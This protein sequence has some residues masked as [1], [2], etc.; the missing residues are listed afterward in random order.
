MRHLPRAVLAALAVA[1]L[2][3]AGSGCGGEADGGPVRASDRAWTTF[4]DTR[5]GLSVSLPPGWHRAR[6]SLTPDLADPREVLSVGSYRPRYDRRSRCAVPGCPS[7]GLHGLRT[8]DVLISIQE[9]GGLSRRFGRSPG[10]TFPARERPFELEPRPVGGKGALGRCARRKLAWWAWTPFGEAG[11]GFYAFV[12]VGRDA[13]PRT[14][15]ELRRVLDS[16]RFRPPRRAAGGWRRLNPQPGGDDVGFD[17][18]GVLAGGRVVFVAGTSGGSDV[19]ARVLDPRTRQWTRQWPAPL[20]WR[21]G[22]SVVGTET[23]ALVW[24]GASSSGLLDDGALYDVD[25]GAWRRLA[26]G[27]LDARA[28]HTAVW[29]GTRMMVWGG[30]GDRP[31]RPLADGAT[32]DPHAGTWDRIAP[33]P[34]RA[35]D[36]HAA[37]AVPGGGMVVWGGCCRGSRHPFADGALLAR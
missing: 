6:E 32:Y 14:R 16:L 9:R 34:L 18:H 23:H 22:A 33:A 37:V 31:R 26:P 36:R 1:A 20:R 10:A 24:G 28:F 29:A 12:A 7:P 8:T 5:R 27:P 17:V 13:S 25:G 19:Y 3:A 35:R 4:D 30:I 15:R 11:R 2:L 21:I